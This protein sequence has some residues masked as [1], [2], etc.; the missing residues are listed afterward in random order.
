MKLSDEHKFLII[1]IAFT[2]LFA[3]FCCFAAFLLDKISN[4]V[5]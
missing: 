4:Q 5:R 1:I 2:A 3:M